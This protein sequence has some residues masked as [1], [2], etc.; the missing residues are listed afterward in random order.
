MSLNIDTKILQKVLENEQLKTA[1]Q[2]ETLITDIKTEN[3]EDINKVF[4]ETD[5]LKKVSIVQ[6]LFRFKKGVLRSSIYKSALNNVKEIILQINNEL[7]LIQTDINYVNSLYFT[8]MRTIPY[9]DK[10]EN[11]KK[12]NSILN[13]RLAI[14]N[15]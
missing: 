14:I 13:E 8:T 11:L 4:E 1:Q 5:L 2:T 7:E 15:F 9:Y 10:L 3:I 6:E 12:F